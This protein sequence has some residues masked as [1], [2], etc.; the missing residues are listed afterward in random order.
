MKSMKAISLFIVDDNRLFSLSLKGFI[1]TA[2]EYLNI[3][4]HIFYTGESC[5]DSLI[6]MNPDLVILD[7]EL[8]S[9]SP[10]AA[11]G[12]VVLEFIKKNSKNSSVIMLTSNSQ[13]DL[14]LSS[15]NQGVSD[16]VIKSENN[17]KKIILSI[18]K[19]INKIFAEH[20]EI[21]MQKNMQILVDEKRLKELQL[22]NNELAFEKGENEKRTFEL[23]LITDQKIELEKSKNIIE[24]RNK[25]MIDSIVYAKRI[26]QAKLPKKE[27]IYEALKDSFV[28]Y[29]PKDIVS[30]DFY[31][32]QKRKESIFI[33]VADC[34]GHGVPGALMSMICSEKLD[35][36]ISLSSDTSEILGYLNK[37][38][39][40]S[41]QQ[42][43]HSDST[44]DGMDIAICEIDYSKKR[45]RYAGANRPIW[46]IRNGVD[47]LEEIKGTKK[48]IGGLTED[49]QYFQ[50]HDLDF[51]TGDTF[52][53][54]TDGY[55]DQFGGKNGKKIMTTRFKKILLDIQSINMQQ[56][57]LY[58]NEFYNDWKSGIEQVDDI[59]ILG[60]RL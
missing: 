55:S 40:N 18:S 58:L 10:M 47:S 9:H 46:L 17:F 21:A 42:S 50:S 54:A 30:G 29:Q 15:F 52:Y 37:G 4:I 35:E 60:V 59:L 14:A 44:R 11:N 12:L 57:K 49:D 5:M 23:T 38:V 39:K 2:F 45:I 24:D 19:A 36:A 33:A 3:D 20:E 48:A 31:Y 6:K 16:Y 56:Q 22:I 34:T 27:D 26:Q 51:E 13:I 1:E 25:E 53:L 8:N 41:L 28:L 7:F 43:T 32:F